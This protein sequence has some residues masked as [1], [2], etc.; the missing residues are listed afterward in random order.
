[1]R[2]YKLFALT[3]LL[4]LTR[5]CRAARF[6]PLFDGKDL[7]GWTYVGNTK[8]YEVNDGILVCP[9][10]CY[11]NLFTT[12][13]YSDF[14]FK[15][16]YKL[17]PNANNG[18]GIRAPF[19]GD[20]AYMG[21]EIQVLDNSGSMYKHLEPGQYC[22]SIYKVAAAKRGALKPVGDWNHEEITAIGR[23]IKIVINGKTVVSANLNDITDP[24]I[25]AEHPGMLRSTGHIGFLGHEPGEVDFR[26]IYVADLS[27]PLPQ[28]R[29]PQGFTALFDGKDLK[30]WKGLVGNPVTRAKMTPDQLKAATEK[31]TVEAVK[32]WKVVDGVI[33]YD[34]KNDNLCTDKQ[35]G[36]FEMLVDWKIEP[37]GDSGIY[38]RGSPQVQIWNNPLGSG[39]LYNNEKNP[40]N[41]L[42]F[43]DNPIGEWNH[44]R[45]LMVGDKV[46][47]YLNNK[48]VVWN[49][50]MENY[51]ERDKP[52]FP[53]EQIELQ[54][55]WS[56]LFFKN[57]YIRTLPP[58]LP[59][60]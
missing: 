42:V 41:P 57:I 38:L 29:P 24:E 40:S 3:L 56:P 33:T 16:D 39:G 30:G 22:G 18:I 34:G 7:N 17:T 11:G 45:I 50:T 31:A 26:N 12:K 59:G 14:I 8:G 48:L 10:G 54:H 28:N 1:M 51:W 6:I 9:A 55:H 53:K 23:R 25:L 4:I 37:R 35:Y 36:N 44:F 20:A 43:A 32:H 49:T 19:Q 58:T 13:K 15:C 5:E 46:T 47:V 21:M 52:I 27:R 60:Q 2:I